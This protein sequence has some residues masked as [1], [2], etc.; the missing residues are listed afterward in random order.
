MFRRNFSKFYLLVGLIAA[1]V[2]LIFLNYLGWLDWPKR[3]FS[4]AVVPILK[5]FEAVGHKTSGAL[6]VLFN[7]KIIIREN[8][9]LRRENQ[10]LI[11]KISGLTEMAQENKILR[12]QLQIELPLESKIMQADLVGFDSGKVGAYFF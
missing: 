8:S 11:L 5:P 7:I 1:V 6:S 4:K 10:E 12:Q 2:L 9:E 3:I